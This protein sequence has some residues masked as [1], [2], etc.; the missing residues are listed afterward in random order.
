MDLY[1]RFHDDRWYVAVCIIF[2]VSSRRPCDMIVY[3]ACYRHTCIHRCGM[4]EAK[5]TNYYGEITWHFRSLMSG[6]TNKKPMDIW[7]SWSNP[8]CH[9]SRGCKSTIPKTTIETAESS[10]SSTEQC[11]SPEVRIFGSRGFGAAK[12]QIPSAYLT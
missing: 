7:I 9:L 6:K 12:S 10:S 4:S 5:I 8:Q 1:C 2:D 11:S 3:V